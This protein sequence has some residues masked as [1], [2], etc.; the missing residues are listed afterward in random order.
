M[1]PVRGDSGVRSEM[2]SSLCWST[3]LIISLKK[4][5]VTEMLSPR[6]QAKHLLWR[7]GVSAQ[8]KEETS[9]LQIPKSFSSP[10]EVEVTFQELPCS[11]IGHKHWTQAQW[12][13]K[14][15]ST[16]L[17]YWLS[18]P[19]KGWKPGSW[20]DSAEAK[21]GFEEWVLVKMMESLEGTSSEGMDEVLPGSHESK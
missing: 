20:C 13:T 1:K 19:Q 7:Q 17:W 15:H 12:A 11:W 8:G 4:Q 18:V 16:I 3:N 21:E 10:K 5:R 2:Y 14:I 6:C 9:P